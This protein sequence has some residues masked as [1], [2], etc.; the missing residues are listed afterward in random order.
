MGNCLNHLRLLPESARVVYWLQL[1]SVLQ[2]TGFYPAVQVPLAPQS[3]PRN[4]QT[5]IML[6]MPTAF[7]SGNP[8]KLRLSCICDGSEYLLV[9]NQD[10]ELRPWGNTSSSAITRSHRMI[11]EFTDRFTY[12]GSHPLAWT[13]HPA[14]ILRRI[15]LSF[16]YFRQTAWPTSGSGQIEFTDEDTALQCPCHLRT[17]IWLGDMDSPEGWRTAIRS[18]PHDLPTT[19]LRNP[20]VPFCHDRL[21]H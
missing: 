8:V 9:E 17:V 7:L 5:K 18:V 14:E 3:A 6:M 10:P 12:L 4:S 11:V 16:K 1:S 2:S 21:S 15:R 20:L 19:D 13:F